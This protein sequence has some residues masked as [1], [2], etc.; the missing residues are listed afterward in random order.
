MGL[1][2]GGS[3]IRDNIKMLK[4]PPH[5][6]VGTPG[7]VFDLLKRGFIE[8]INIRMCVLYDADELFGRGFYQ[9][10]QDIVSRMS[11]ETQV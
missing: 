5:I 8:S 9:Q 4:N 1:L 10:I 11:S 6:L 2:V 3:A 7:R